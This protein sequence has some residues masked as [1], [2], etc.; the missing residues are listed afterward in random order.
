MAFSP[1]S[2]DWTLTGQNGVSRFWECLRRP[3]RHPYTA[4][5]TEHG[6]AHEWDAVLVNIVRRREDGQWR[7][8]ILVRLVGSR[9]TA[10]ARRFRKE[11]QERRRAYRGDLW[12]QLEW[13]VPEPASLMTRRTKITTP[14]DA[15]W[16]AYEPAE[17][18]RRS[19]DRPR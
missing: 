6:D 7:H 13:R 11:R 16:S 8:V 3:R 19:A 17:Q 1:H 18:A 5:I 2:R 15:D 12:A 9:C 10:G 14:K 4:L